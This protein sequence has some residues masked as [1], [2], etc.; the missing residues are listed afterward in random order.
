MP[1]FEIVYVKLILGFGIAYSKFE[2]L[3]STYTNNI[4]LQ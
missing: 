3:S 1:L 4:M 2:C